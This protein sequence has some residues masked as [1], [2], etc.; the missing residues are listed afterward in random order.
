M[1]F[2]LKEMKKNILKTQY[3][4]FMQKYIFYLLLFFSP[5]FSLIGR[6]VSTSPFVFEEIEIEEKEADLFSILNLSDHGLSFE[7]FY[8][9]MSGYEK[10]HAEGKLENPDLLTIIDFSQSSKNKRLY[11]L[12]LKEQ[13]LLHH[14]WVSHGRNTG[15]EFAENFSNINGS[16]K[17]SLGFYLTKGTNM[18]ASVGFSMILEGL[19]K[20]FNDNAKMRQ[21]IMHGAD[22][23]TEDF[24]KR[25]GRLGRSFGCPAVSPEII[26]PIVNSIRDGSLMFIYYPDDHYLSNSDL[27][28]DFG[29]NS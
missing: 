29:M 10:L 7:A 20:G 16:W 9:A 26:K 22:Y 11:V 18:G 23:A 28:S 14:T 21:I 5:V 25:T 15:D 8:Y 2:S 6:E 27:L 24:I 12:D 13:K 17:S 1:V 4:L 19:E 3:I